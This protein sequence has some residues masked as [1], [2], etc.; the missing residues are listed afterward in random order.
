MGGVPF[1]MGLLEEGSEPPVD[2]SPIV[3]A[4]SLLRLY[5]LRPPVV[6]E[7]CDTFH[8]HPGA[9]HW[10]GGGG[11]TKGRVKLHSGKYGRHDQKR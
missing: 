4:A 11:V 6:T 2:P 10:G 5:W 7:K 1:D 8:A 3:S 9:W